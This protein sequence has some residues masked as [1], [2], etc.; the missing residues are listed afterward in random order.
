M[1]KN[2]KP[3]L[4]YADGRCQGLK[5][6]VVED[7]SFSSLSYQS[8]SFPS[9][10]DQR[11]RTGRFHNL[12]ARQTWVPRGSG[13]TAVVNP[14]STFNAN[15]NGIGSGHSDHTSAP[16][17]PGHGNATRGR[18]PWPTNHRRDGRKRR[19]GARLRSLRS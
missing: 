18:K 19:T 6:A 4:V 8:M 12:H 15:P 10:N 17:N 1:D 5:A 11:D 2:S 7:T 3:P 13:P 14:P 16:P 9:R